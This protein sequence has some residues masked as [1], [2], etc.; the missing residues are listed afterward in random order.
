MN[1]SPK[2]LPKGFV[3]INDLDKSIRVNLKYFGKDNF[4]GKKIPHYKAN[5]GILT[6]E[7]ADALIKAQKIF[8]SKGYSIVIYDAYRPAS[9]VKYFVE[10]MNDKNDMIRKKYH[11]PYIKEKID[12]MDIYINSK[13][14]HSKGST[15]DIS[16]I[17]LDKELLKESIYEERTFNDKIYPFNNDNTIE[18]GTSFDLMEP[19][20][21][22]DNNYFNF[23][24]EQKNNRKLIRDVMESVGFKVIPEEW[25]HF[26]LKNE[27][28]IDKYFD[29]E[30]E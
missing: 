10:W 26:T 25:W 27:P 8:I 3:Y 17:E 9:S 30:I 20:S 18:C 13:S 14:G 6:K 29:F 1:S 28:Y 12:M 5:K 23:T 11:Y 4:I 7:A 2:D 24:D 19:A 22:A 21:W 15:V 16:I